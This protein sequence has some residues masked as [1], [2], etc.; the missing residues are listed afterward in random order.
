MWLEILQWGTIFLNI[1]GYWQSRK[2]IKEAWDTTETRIE[3]LEQLFRA[4]EEDFDF[5]INHLIEEI[6]LLKENEGL[7]DLRNDSEKYQMF[8]TL[9]REKK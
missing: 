7:Y 8:L 2:R 3:S 5:H 9:L 1:F 4:R 6:R